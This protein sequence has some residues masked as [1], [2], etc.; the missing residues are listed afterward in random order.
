MAAEEDLRPASEDELLH[1]VVSAG[2]EARLQTVESDLVD[3][4]RDVKR[5]VL[6][7]GA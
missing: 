5:Y 6:I 4:E 3:L 1:R 7:S 2:T